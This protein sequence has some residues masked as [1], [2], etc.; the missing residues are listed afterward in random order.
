MVSQAISRLAIVPARGGSKRIPRKNIRDFCGKPMIAH[1][2]AA[3]ADSGLFE[4]IHVSTDDTEI[5][6]VAAGL[7]HAPE[8][9][10]PAS[11]ADE[12]TPIMPVL[13]W[14]V[15]HYLD[16]G[17]R[18]DQ[19]WL[20]MPCAPLID[21]QDLRAAEKLFAAHE[22]R[23]AVIGVSP[24]PAPIEWAFNRRETGEL[25][26]VQEGAFAIRSQDLVERYYDAGAFAVFTHDQVAQS[27]GAGASITYAGHVL[28]KSKAIDI[29][30]EDDWR[31][32]ENVFRG[33][34]T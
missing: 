24:Y 28:E 33:R 21:S 19:V 5:S 17:L 14:V 10:R 2:L 16:R 9:A 27:S 3:A 13:K 12:F 1:I 6:A 29:D 30:S 7:G 11:L 15:E 32:A 34:G 18:F 8:F 4:R 25:S 20:L 31:F 23:Q 22:G 26:A